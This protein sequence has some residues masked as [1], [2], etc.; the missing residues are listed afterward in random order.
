MTPRSRPASR[1]RAAVL[2]TLAAL[3]AAALAGMVAMAGC[4]GSGGAG[5]AQ[6]D[7]AMGPESAK[8]TVVE[9]ASVTCGH[10]AAKNALAAQ[11]ANFERY[12]PAA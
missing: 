7:M 4:G 6:G 5:A 2:A 9:Y 11:L 12:A 8:V 1:V 10:C 3:T